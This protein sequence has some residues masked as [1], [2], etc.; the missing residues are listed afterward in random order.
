M[1]SLAIAKPGHDGARD[2][3]S[4]HIEVPSRRVG[5]QGPNTVDLGQVC[6]AVWVRDGFRI[7]PPP[8]LATRCEVTLEA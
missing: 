2:P 1:T 3:R 5:A 7:S 8:S 4:A 6:V